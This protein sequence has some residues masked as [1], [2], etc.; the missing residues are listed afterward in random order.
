MTHKYGDLY[1]RVA[2]GGPVHEHASHVIPQFTGAAAAPALEDTTVFVTTIGDAVNFDD[3]I[4][5]LAAQTARCRIEL[6]DRVAPMS[7]AFN[8]MQRRCRTPYYVQVDEDML[9][10]PEALATLH[11]LIHTADERVPMACAPLWDCDTER[12]ILGIKIYRHEIVRRFPYRNTISCD[13]TQ[14]QS[15][16]EAGH[17]SLIL[18]CEE[19]SAQCLGEH[20]KHYNPRT[21]FL[22]W[23]RLFH[24]RNEIGRL[25]WLEPWPARLLERYIKTGDQTHLYAALGAIAGIAG[26][27]DENRELDWRDANPAFQRM[28]RYFPLTED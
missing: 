19:A 3:C 6:I 2:K 1:A 25:H 18:S 28:L 10:Y 5:H 27:A 22:R 12:P 16:E 14:L 26:R 15:M 21:V 23:Q 11:D 17:P 20:G 13:I 24:K 7:A 8:Q 4:A 9:L